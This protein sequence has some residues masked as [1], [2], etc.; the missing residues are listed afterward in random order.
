MKS[1]SFLYTLILGVLVLS[2]CSKEQIA[3]PEENDP[4]FVI[5][6]TV[7]SETISLTAGDNEA[8]MFTSTKVENGVRLFTGE[9][10]NGETSIELGIFDGNLDQPN[11]LPEVDLSSAVLKFA[12]RANEP[13]IVLS[14]Q[15]LNVNLN[16]SSIVWYINGTSTYTDEAPIMEPGKY[17]VCAV[18][19]FTGSGEVQQ[20]CDEIIIGYERSAN[21]YINFSIN[22]GL[23]F[24]DVVS[25]GASI[26]SVSWLLD[27]QPLTNGN[28][29]QESIDSA[30]HV[31]TAKVVF[32]NGAIREKSCL[33]NGGNPLHSIPDFSIFEITSGNGFPNQDYHIKLTV[34]HEG[35][36]YKS[37][38]ANN[39]NSSVTLL[40]MEYFGKNANEKDVYKATVEI[41]AI[42]MDMD[43]EKLLPLNFIATLGVEVP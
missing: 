40:G 27:G 37:V 3:I 4:V 29:L 12:H 21:C 35:K 17:D 9:L 26:E 28:S 34:K 2:S 1:V 42:V 6:G 13:L 11:H 5:E 43:T 23:V 41:S 33:I 32:D 19:T 22:N 25:T 20:L 24:A 8:Y 15:N 38:Y 7:G 10:S 18:V 14:K 39:E 31:L 16:I 36:T 30:A